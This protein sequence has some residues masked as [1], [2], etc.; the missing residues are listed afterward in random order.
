MDGLC[1]EEELVY[2][3]WCGASASQYIPHTENLHPSQAC[4]GKKRVEK[5]YI[6][7]LDKRSDLESNNI[8][9]MEIIDKLI[10][11]VPGLLEMYI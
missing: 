9:L 3:L 8:S 2:C 4:T 11:M 1:V 7:L 6:A 5:I 10:I